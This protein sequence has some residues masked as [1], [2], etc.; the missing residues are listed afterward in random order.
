MET[1]ILAGNTTQLRMAAENA[2]HRSM[3][4]AE[5]HKRTMIEQQKLTEALVSQRNRFSFGS[6]RQ[7]DMLASRLALNFSSPFNLT[8]IGWLP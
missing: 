5:N 6:A 1:T 3:L 2:A 4:I 7:Y 8:V